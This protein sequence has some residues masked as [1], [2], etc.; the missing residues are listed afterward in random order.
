MAILRQVGVAEPRQIGRDEMEAIGQK[1]DEVAK[2][3]SRSRKPVEQQQLW[4]ASRPRFTVKDTE[5]VD[6]GG[7]VSDGGH[8]DAPRGLSA[9]PILGTGHAFS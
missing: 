4:A 5:T 7:F 2:H 9:S 3:M 1:R 6:V 8:G